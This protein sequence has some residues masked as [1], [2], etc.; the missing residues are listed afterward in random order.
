MMQEMK[1][2]VF[3]FLT[4]CLRWVMLRWL[5]RIISLNDADFEY[6]AWT[7]GRLFLASPVW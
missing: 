3:E 4:W 5:A 6:N 2:K 7:K 1:R